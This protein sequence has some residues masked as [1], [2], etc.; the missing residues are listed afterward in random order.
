[1]SISN[2]MHK[3]DNLHDLSN[4]KM[5]KNKNISKNISKNKNKLIGGKNVNGLI[6]IG[7]SMSRPAS[8]SYEYLK[9]ESASN[10]NNN[11]NSE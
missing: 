4:I 7:H 8:K 3:L 1:M 9:N 2:S 10:L 6:H 5:Y 11:S